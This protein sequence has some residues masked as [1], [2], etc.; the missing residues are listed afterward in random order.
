MSKKSKKQRSKRRDARRRAA[1]AAGRRARKK[2]AAARARGTVQSFTM[3]SD[4]SYSVT[5]VGADEIEAL[6]TYIR[7][8]DRLPPT[9]PFA[10]AE[11]RRQLAQALGILDDLGATDDEVLQAI[12]VLG[13]IPDPR[14]LTALVARADSTEVHADIAKHAADE[15]AGWLESER[16]RFG[17]PPQRAAMMN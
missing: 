17:P 16:T 9:Y 3:T 4:G 2:A 6:N 8:H 14:A 10:P 12:V 5:T 15:C 11:Q 13:H 7:A 1:R